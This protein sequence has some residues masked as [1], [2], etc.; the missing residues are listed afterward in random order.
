MGTFSK[1]FASVGGFVA[2]EKDVINYVKHHARHFMFTAAMPPSAAATVLE[3]M[4]IVQEEP[5][6]LENL[7][8][9]SQKMS[10]ELTRMGY[11]TL[12]SQTPIVPLLIGD[13]MMALAFSQ[14]LYENGVFATP[15]VRPAVPEGCALMRTS[16]MASHTEADLDYSLTVLEKL[17]KAFGILGNPERKAA[18]EAVAQT[19]FG[20]RGSLATPKSS[21]AM[22][23]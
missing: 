17:G 23:A 15:V 18:M 9:N 22:L 4:R 19:H 6:H 21:S 3:C 11:F 14:K 12:G 7:R 1:S 13:D 10:A 8:R 2:G 16:Y 5:H 20:K